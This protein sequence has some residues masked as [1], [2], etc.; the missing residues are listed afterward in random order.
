MK[1]EYLG[2]KTHGTVREYLGYLDPWYGAR[3]LRAARYHRC[4]DERAT[5]S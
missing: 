5:N 1:C 4:Q 2:Y 3:R